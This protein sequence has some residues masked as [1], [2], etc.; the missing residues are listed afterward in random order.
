[1][2]KLGFSYAEIMGMPECE[3]IEYMEAM[4]EVL[5]KPP[6]KPNTD[7]ANTIPAKTYKV[8]KK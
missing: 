6:P 5:P 2:L 3:V 7:P 8:M 1:M 4:A